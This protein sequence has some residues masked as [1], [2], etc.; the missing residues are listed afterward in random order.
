MKYQAGGAL[1]QH[2][3]GYVVRPADDELLHALQEG[4]FCY[5]LTARQ[6]GKSSLKVRTITRLKD[7]DWQC[8][9]VD[10]T[11]VGIQQVEQEQWYYAFL[12]LVARSFRAKADF[13]AWWQ[14]QAQTTLID[15][16]FSFWGDYL[17][18]RTEGP[19]AIFIDE[20]DS[21]LGLDPTTFNTDDFFAAIRAIYNAQATEPA[22]RRLHFCVLGVAAPD[23]L[24]QDPARTLFNVGKAINLTNLRQEDAEVLLPGLEGKGVASTAL[25]QEV[26][27]WTHPMGIPT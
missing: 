25:L 15:R 13:D 9:D 23:D 10:I 24:M 26:M 11:R 1:K 27:H 19:L 18:P 4:E 20:I 8:A 6:M 12:R 22:L 16:F 14:A 17:L 3:P 2:D 5:V 7:L 21:L